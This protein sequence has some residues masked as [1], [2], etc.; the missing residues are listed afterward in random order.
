MN[1]EDGI[2]G[3]D[4]LK[5]DTIIPLNMKFQSNFEILLCVPT[6]TS[7]SPSSVIGA[8]PRFVIFLKLLEN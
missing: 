8:E 1:F 4:V 5:S 3:R 6:F 2:V 7:K